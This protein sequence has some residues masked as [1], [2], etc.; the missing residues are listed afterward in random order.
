MHP[1]NTSLNDTSNCAIKYTRDKIT[2]TKYEDT[3][4]KCYTG[5]AKRKV[6]VH[7]VKG[8]SLRKDDFKEYDVPDGKIDPLFTVAENKNTFNAENIANGVICGMSAKEANDLNGDIFMSGPGYFQDYIK[9]WRILY[10]S[11]TS[12]EN[13]YQI[14]GFMAI[15]IDPKYPSSDTKFLLKIHRNIQKQ[16]DMKVGDY[17]RFMH[18]DQI[19][20][21]SDLSEM[22][23]KNIIRKSLSKYECVSICENGIAPSFIEEKNEP[24]L[25]G[26]TEDD[27]KN[28]GNKCVKCNNRLPPYNGKCL[29]SPWLGI[30]I[31]SPNASKNASNAWF[32]EVNNSKYERKNGW[33]NPPKTI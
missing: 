30:G 31:G 19:S 6:P 28:A 7:L 12:D 5:F 14:L 23:K 2:G 33:R 20:R 29:Q 26:S 18:D 15:K 27:I 3:C 9:N 4:E 21:I 8:Q 25:E 1:L 24:Y 10:L 13:Y 16:L 11:E 17:I 22:E 32:P